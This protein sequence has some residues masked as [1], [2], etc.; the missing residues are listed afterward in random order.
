MLIGCV[1]DAV[2]VSLASLASSKFPSV[3]MS[4]DSCLMLVW[5]RF[6]CKQNPMPSWSVLWMVGDIV[7]D[8]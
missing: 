5:L 3:L 7:V 1:L 4:V 6:G 8:E 2:R